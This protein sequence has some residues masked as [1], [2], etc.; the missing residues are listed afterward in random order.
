MGISYS[1]SHPKQVEFRSP[2][3]RVTFDWEGEGGESKHGVVGGL[4]D[5]KEA[6]PTPFLENRRAL[7]GSPA[8][9]EIVEQMTM[10]K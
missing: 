3:G 9:E 8:L 4:W 1:E 2:E 5:V 7:R 10:G 6:R